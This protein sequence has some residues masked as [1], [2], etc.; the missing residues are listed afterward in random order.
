[1]SPEGTLIKEGGMYKNKI[2]ASLNLNQSALKASGFLQLAVLIQSLSYITESHLDLFSE[3]LEILRSVH[4]RMKHCYNKWN[5]GKCLW[6]KKNKTKR[7]K[8]TTSPPPDFKIARIVYLLAYYVLSVSQVC[9]IMDN[10]LLGILWRSIPTLKSS[11][12]FCHNFFFF[13]SCE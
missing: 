11:R 4:S 7:Q 12:L 3:L 13:I 10:S 6:W 8:P 9:C 1:M 2:I 5:L